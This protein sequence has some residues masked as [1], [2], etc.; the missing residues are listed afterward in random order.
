M[1]DRVIV[2]GAR[3]GLSRTPGTV[4]SGPPTIG[5]DTYEV[6]TEIL[7]YGEDRVADLY[8]AEVLE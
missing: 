5:Q 8:A 1:F 7:G 2:E 6:L 4:A 3:F